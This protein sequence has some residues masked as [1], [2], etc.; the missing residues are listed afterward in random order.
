MIPSA[1]N[2]AMGDCAAG[3]ATNTILYS[4]LVVKKIIELPGGQINDPCLE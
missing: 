1:L 4:L 2:T 3:M